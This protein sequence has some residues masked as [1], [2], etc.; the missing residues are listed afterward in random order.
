MTAVTKPPKYRS[1][2]QS[3]FV[4]KNRFFADFAM[5][6]LFF[7]LTPEFAHFVMKTFFLIFTQ[8]FGEFRGYF[9]M[10]N[11]FHGL[12]SRIRGKKVFV[13]PQK[14]SLCLPPSVA[15]LDIYIFVKE[16]DV[17]FCHIALKKIRGSDLKN[18]GKLGVGGK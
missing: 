12:H 5:K 15:L 7:V 9:V 2:T 6:V 14:N 13:T 11:F 17:D 1:S 3:V 4:G 18:W 10:K 16:S 8:E